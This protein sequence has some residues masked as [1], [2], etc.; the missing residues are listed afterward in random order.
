MM[1]IEHVRALEILDSRGT[2][3]V[4]AQVWLA[5][6]SCASAQ[7]PSGAST[8]RHEAIELRDGDLSRHAGKGVLRAVR[9]IETELGPAVVGLNAADQAAID[10]RLIETDGTPNKQR[11]GAN[12]VL[13]VSCAVA[14]VVANALQVPLWKYLAGTRKSSLPV[15]MV[16][17]ISGGLHAGRN[18]EFQDFLV[19]PRGY[20]DLAAALE[21]VVAVHR[22]TGNVLAARGCVLTGVADEGGWGPRLQSNEA[23]VSVLH[24]AIQLV[25]ASHAGSGMDI[26][27]D[28]ASSHFYENGRYR[29]E[30]RDL[31]AAGM[32][33][34]LE[35]WLGKYGV[36]SIEDPLAEDDWDGWQLLTSRLWKQVRLVGDDLFVTNLARLEKGIH[37]GAGNAVLVK[38]NQIGTLTETFQVI[39]RA[40]EA[41]FGAVISARSGE[42]EDSFLADLAVASGAGEIKIGSITRSER[43]AKY[44][45]LLEIEKWEWPTS[46]G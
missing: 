27:L 11:L 25:G 35:P 39:D 14:R 8:G 19:R 42:T 37:Q 30:G 46:K 43:L 15:P 34:Y 4:Q 1:K 9:N 20:P 29:L 5:D 18:L 44:N 41:G 40:R 31:T 38:M 32:A 3:A 36:R 21:A 33:D 17:I 24:E 10:A 23:A 13:A 45:R 6:G 26:V 12:A 7:V 2:P 16:N 28:V 22:V